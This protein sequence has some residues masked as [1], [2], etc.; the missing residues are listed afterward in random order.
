MTKQ[1]DL[2]YECPDQFKATPIELFFVFCFR[3]TDASSENR[4]MVLD[5]SSAAAR[6]PNTLAQVYA[7]FPRFLNRL[8][9]LELAGNHFCAV[10]QI[11]VDRD[12]PRIRVESYVMGYFSELVPKKCGASE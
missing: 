4:E 1:Q 6:F 9:K 10:K 8:Q 12:D 11:V 3:E 2:F 5:A 7:A